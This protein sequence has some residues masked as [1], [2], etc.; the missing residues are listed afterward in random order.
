MRRLIKIIRNILLLAIAAIVV[1][2]GVLAFN[3]VSH[4]SRQLQVA[5]IPRAAVDSEGAATRLSEAIRFRTISNFDN[6][7]QDAEALRGLQAH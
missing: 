7:D 5:S 2:A 4:G 1:V 6:P 3:V